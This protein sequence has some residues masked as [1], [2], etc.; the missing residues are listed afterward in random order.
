[1]VLALVVVACATPHGVPDAQAPHETPSRPS[2]E[3]RTVRTALVAMDLCFHWGGEVGGDM[4]PEREADIRAGFDRDCPAAVDAALKAWRQYPHNPRLREALAEF[5]D[6]IA[7][8]GIVGTDRLTA[9]PALVA[10]Y[11]DWVERQ[12]P[13]AYVSEYTVDRL[14]PPGSAG[15]PADG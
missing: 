15:P 4:G 8:S 3:G 12:S 5:I 2:P 11:C 6:H 14:C 10:L 13:D 1:M 7:L 9:D